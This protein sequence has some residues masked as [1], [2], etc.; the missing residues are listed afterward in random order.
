M[1]RAIEKDGRIHTKFNQTET[2]TGRLS[3]AEPNLQNIPVKTDIGREMR[4]FFCAKEGHFLI[5]ADYSQIELRIL[6]DISGDENMIN[7]FK[8]GEDIHTITATRIFNIPASMITESM[9]NMAKTINFGIIYGMS[10]FSLAKEIDVSRKE[11]NLYINHYFEH[12]DGVRTYMDDTLK[13]A[14]EN[15]FVK[16]KFE[17]RRYLPEILSKN[18]NVRSFGKRVARNMPIQGT[19]ADII[20][21]AMIRV[22][23][24]LEQEQLKSRLILQVHDELLVEAPKDEVTYVSELLKQEMQGALD[25]KI[26]LTVNISS[27]KTWYDAKQS[28]K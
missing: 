3:S 10:A 27:G 14:K 9:R 19:A 22:K 6:A 26:P 17:R 20:K 8:N 2:K 11:A 25:L 16:T 15:G 1:L 23:N 12:Y 18:F 13:F 28:I 21:I 7:S 5:D 4:K 24:R